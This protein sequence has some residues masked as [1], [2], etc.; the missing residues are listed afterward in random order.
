MGGLLGLGVGLFASGA[1]DEMFEGDASVSTAVGA[2]REAVSG[3]VVIACVSAGSLWLA[4]ASAISGG[5]LLAAA[6]GVVGPV[7]CG[8]LLVIV[9]GSPRVGEIV[10]LP[11]AP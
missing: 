7:S 8:Y 6:A 4:Y 5:W 3:A 2:G 11:G 9:T 1:I 10:L